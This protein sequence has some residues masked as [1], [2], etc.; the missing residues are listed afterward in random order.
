[1]ES[2]VSR[3][4]KALQAVDEPN[5]S[6]LAASRTAEGSA[7]QL[8]E[9]MQTEMKE[10]K[11]SV[12]MED[13]NKDSRGRSNEQKNASRENRLTSGK[14]A[15]TPKGER[16]GRKEKVIEGTANAI[17][18][19][20]APAN[21]DKVRLRLRSLLENLLLQAQERSEPIMSESTLSRPAERAYN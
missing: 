17:I 12:S 8:R 9:A 3:W 5:H 11:A 19:L 2:M 10:S 16:R 20:F 1:M 4:H 7:K 15:E 6:R 18:E 14:K 13:R 21:P